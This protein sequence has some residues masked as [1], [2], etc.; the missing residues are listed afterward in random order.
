MDKAEG[1]ATINETENMEEPRGTFSDRLENEIFGCSYDKEDL[2]I[3]ICE[4]NEFHASNEFI[5]TKFEE[6]QS[7]VVDKIKQTK[8]GGPTSTRGTRSTVLVSR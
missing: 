2:A 3:L 1:R 7:V 5:L 8:T 4:I 6:L